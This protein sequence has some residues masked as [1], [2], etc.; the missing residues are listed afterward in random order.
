[1]SAIRGGAR[2]VYKT[3]SRLS[4]SRQYQIYA[5]NKLAI[6]MYPTA[7]GTFV[8]NDRHLS[9]KIA[10]TFCSVNGKKT[11]IGKKG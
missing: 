6:G 7:A 4:A 8:D 2:R 3:K 9:S 5:H 10:N 1:M 11:Y